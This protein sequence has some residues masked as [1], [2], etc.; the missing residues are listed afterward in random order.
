MKRLLYRGLVCLALPLALVL[1]GWRGLRD[2]GYWR[3][4]DERFG[5]GARSPAGSIW[6]HAVSV[7]EVQAAAALVQAL[8]EAHPGIP[9]TLTT[10]TATGA[11]RARVLFG[12][13]VRVRFLPFDTTGSV[14]RFFDRVRP[15]VAIVV[16]KEVWP[17]LYH[18][19]GVRRVPLVL[20]SAALAPH[21][22]DRYRRLGS[23]FAETLARGMIVAAQTEADAARFRAIG[24]NPADTHVIGNLKFDLALPAD[25]VVAG[26]ALRARHGWQQRCVLVGGS[27]YEDEEESLLET[28][29][30]LR[31]EGVDLALVLAPRH[32]PRFAAVADRLRAAGVNFARQSALQESTLQQSA[33][34]ESAK[35]VPATDVLLLDSIGE[36]PAA[37]A[38]ADIAF[39]GGSLVAGVGG[40]NL[41]EPAAL[42]VATLT[43]P[44]GY[45]APDIVAALRNA[46]AL[47]VVA[48]ADSL[49]AEVLRLAG[50]AAERA[51][52]GEIG[53]CY[54]AENRGTL[55]RLLTLLQPIILTASRAASASR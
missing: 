49:T 31:A 29:R 33:L 27:T 13:D 3:G 53:R 28:Q 44:H 47:G 46:G 10:T 38:A 32:P 30:S 23:L 26:E 51:R 36:L 17:N 22:L 4:L 45:N 8:R 2:R 55:Q 35:A 50:D 34:Q 12:A 9:L 54:V 16:E 42:G 18:E 21:A 5:F 15:L 7:G 19:C 48:D 14:R 40:H 39:V 52:R 25:A 43:G 24:A 41:L 37:Y 20:A 1:I 11:A 6:V